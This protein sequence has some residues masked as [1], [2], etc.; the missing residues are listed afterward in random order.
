MNALE[1]FAQLAARSRAEAAP[2]VDVTTGVLGDIRQA[3]RQVARAESFNPPLLVFSGLSL[4]AASIVAVLAIQSWEMLADPLAGL[5]D[6][7][8]MVM[9]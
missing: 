8:T 4:L 9:R 5:F 6:S 1:K 3:A 7:L 2:R